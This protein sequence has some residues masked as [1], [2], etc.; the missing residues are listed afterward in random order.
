MLDLNSLLLYQHQLDML[1]KNTLG[2]LDGVASL[3]GVAV[4]PEDIIN[5]GVDDW[6][7]MNNIYR[8]EYFAVRL[9]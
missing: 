4:T 1:A 7:V 9:K 3:P 8:P 2:E 5:D 6:V